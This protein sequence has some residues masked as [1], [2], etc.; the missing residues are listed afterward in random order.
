MLHLEAEI[1]SKLS[2]SLV[3]SEACRLN[4]RER[5]YVGAVTNLLLP[6]VLPL[7]SNRLRLK[8]LPTLLRTDSVGKR[9]LG[10]LRP[11]VAIIN[12]PILVIDPPARYV[13]IELPKGCQTFKPVLYTEHRPDSIVVFGCSSKKG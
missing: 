9:E 5:K 4:R 8:L 7:K 3:S 11:P 6:I 10:N 13:F 1:S 2:I 12:F